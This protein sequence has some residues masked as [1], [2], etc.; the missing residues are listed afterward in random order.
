MIAL[1]P[2]NHGVVKTVKKG[3]GLAITVSVRPVEVP[4]VNVAPCH[5]MVSD[6]SMPW[7]HMR[8]F[9]ELLSISLICPRFAGLM[10]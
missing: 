2:D 6:V 1:R 3:S 10:L 4:P 7:Y 8:L 9:G 5:R